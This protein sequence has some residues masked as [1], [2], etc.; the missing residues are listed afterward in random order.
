MAKMIFALNQSLDGYVDHMAFAP[1]PVLFRHFIDDVRGLA[2]SVYGRRIY[3]VTRTCA[4][5]NLKYIAECRRWLKGRSGNRFIAE[6]AYLRPR[7]A[8]RCSNRSGIN[9]LIGDLPDKIGSKRS[10]LSNTAS[11]GSKLLT[12][13]APH[14]LAIHGRWRS[15]DP[16]SCDKQQRLRQNVHIACACRRCR[17]A[18]VEG[19]TRRGGERLAQTPWRT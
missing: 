5:G 15:Y 17:P 13:G 8:G 2:G 3:E 6:T 16:Y 4:S 12:R 19:V 11:L 7:T 10:T 9:T 18:F 1:D 14:Y